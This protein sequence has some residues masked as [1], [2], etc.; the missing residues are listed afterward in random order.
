M[1]LQ[2]SVVLFFH[3][4]KRLDVLAEKLATTSDMLEHKNC[5]VMIAR[6]EK[7][8]VPLVSDYGFREWFHTSLIQGPTSDLKG[9]CELNKFTVAW[10]TA[11]PANEGG[12]VIRWEGAV[13]RETAET[14]TSFATSRELLH[15]WVISFPLKKLLRPA[16]VFFFG[17]SWLVPELVMSYFEESC[18]WIL[19][20]G[21][22]Y[23]NKTSWITLS[24][25]AQFQDAANRRVLWDCVFYRISNIGMCLLENT[26]QIVRS[27]KKQKISLSDLGF[28]VYPY[29]QVKWI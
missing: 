19:G 11:R 15:I 2:V 25:C 9:S 1:R 23:N 3:S 28:H 12:R 14:S 24:V 8:I 6:W 20:H 10:S 13:L 18:L 4:G 17:R 21:N 27:K 26:D 5:S 29:K 16:W 7:H 22:S